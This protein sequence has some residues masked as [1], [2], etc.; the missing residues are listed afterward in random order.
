MR[1]PLGK[2]RGGGFQRVWNLSERGRPIR[3][4]DRRRRVDFSHCTNGIVFSGHVCS[5]WILYHILICIARGAE[6]N[7]LGGG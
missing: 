2:F 5:W 1:G 4:R 6:G 7:F 3:G